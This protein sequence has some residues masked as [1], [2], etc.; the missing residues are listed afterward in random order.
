MTEEN[1][2]SEQS[3][4]DP[5][6]EIAFS[7]P[8][9]G[10]LILYNLVIIV[11][12]IFLLYASGRFNLFIEIFFQLTAIIGIV[13]FGTNTLIF[14]AKLIQK[15]PAFTIDQAGFIDNSDTISAGRVY[16][17]QITEIQE[18]QTMGQVIILVKVDDPDPILANQNLF[19]KLFM[20][21]NLKRF[22]TPVSVTC[23]AIEIDHQKLYQLLQENLKGQE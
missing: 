15:N 5:R 16:W 21:I 1:Q 19:K 7:K 17:E 11:I 12:G 14:T 3:A 18:W 20:A 9:I 10:M 13:I 4:N 22:G 23:G 6:L 8:K 2:N